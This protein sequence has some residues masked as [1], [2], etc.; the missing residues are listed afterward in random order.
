[1][2][3]NILTTAMVAMLVLELG[4]T[5]YR[6]WIKKDTEYKFSKGFYLVALPVLE[7][8]VQ[9]LL[10]YLDV[11]SPASVTLSLKT[12]LTVVLQSLSSVFIYNGSVKQFK[13]Y[14]AK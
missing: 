13:N 4:K 11:L 5:G 1:M 6:K 12:V 8:L 3:E 14:K 10:V 7:L 2:I 9:P